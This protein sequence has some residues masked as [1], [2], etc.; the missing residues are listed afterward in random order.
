QQQR[1]R[2]NAGPGGER[3]G[4][5]PAGRGGGRVVRDRF[6]GGGLRQRRR[7]FLRQLEAVAEDDV[8]RLRQLTGVRVFARAP[9]E[10]PEILE[11][12]RGSVGRVQRVGRGQMAP[13]HRQH[14]VE[15]LRQR[16]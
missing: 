2:R 12:R 11:R 7:Q 14:V 15:V 10:L 6:G 4:L 1:Q 9:V 3:H 13:E 5:A 8:G 16:V